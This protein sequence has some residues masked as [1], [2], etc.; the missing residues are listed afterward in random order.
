MPPAAPRIDRL[1]AHQALRAWW[2]CCGDVNLG[3]SSACSIS[4]QIRLLR[5]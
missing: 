3:S 2:Q 1:P 4:L 5:A